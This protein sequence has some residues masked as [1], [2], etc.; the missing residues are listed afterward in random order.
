MPTEQPDSL[1]RVRRTRHEISLEHGHDPVRLVAHYIA[2][3]QT[4]GEPKAEARP[5]PPR[6]KRLARTPKP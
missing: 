3:Q 1:T 2:L 4:T 5:A 6:R